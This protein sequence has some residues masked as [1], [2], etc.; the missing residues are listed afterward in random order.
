MLRYEGSVLCR[1]SFSGQRTKALGPCTGRVCCAFRFH[2][3]FSVVVDWAGGYCRSSVL[4]SLRVSARLPRLI[5]HYPDGVLDPE[6]RVCWV[7]L[8]LKWQRPVTDS[9]YQEQFV[10]QEYN[11]VEGDK[12][13]MRDA[14]GDLPDEVG[15]L[16]WDQSAG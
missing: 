3:F 10:S 11:P 7:N 15:V 9:Y 1:Q 6:N 8:G 2:R 4:A 5:I 12:I 13:P 16:L 14:D